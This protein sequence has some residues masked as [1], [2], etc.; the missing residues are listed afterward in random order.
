[1]GALEV[2]GKK[3]VPPERTGFVR[4][5]R[6]GAHVA[7]R[8]DGSSISVDAPKTVATVDT[9]WRMAGSTL[10][11]D[12]PSRSRSDEKMRLSNCRRQPSLECAGLASSDASSI[13]CLRP[14]KDHRRNHAGISRRASPGWWVDLRGG[15]K[16]PTR[17]RAQS[18]KLLIYARIAFIFWPRGGQRSE[19]ILDRREF[20]VTVWASRGRGFVPLGLADLA[21]PNLF[22]R[23]AASSA[24]SSSV[25]VDNDGEH[26]Q[27]STQYSTLPDYQE[28]L[29]WLHSV[30][31]PTP[32]SRWTSA[33]RPSSAPTRRSSSTATS[34][35][36]DDQGPVRHQALCAAA[37]RHLPNGRDPVQLLRHLRA[38]RREPRSLHRPPNLP[39]TLAEQ[40]PDLTYL[41]PAQI[42]PTSIGSPGTTSRPT[43]PTSQ[44]ATGETRR[45]TSGVLPFDTPTLV[46]F[47][48]T[49]IY[50]KLGLTP[51]ATWDD[52]FANS[53]AIKVRPD[54]VRLGEHG[55][56]VNV[57]I[58]YEYQAHLA[59]FG[60]SLWAMDGNTITPTINT[61]AALRP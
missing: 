34:P 29:S 5:G 51:P 61:D 56:R 19:G 28:F 11:E 7:V 43:H 31:A 53:Q 38:G 12:G 2:L 50:Q 27:S 21:S 40:Y 20:C 46:L 44:A 60:G 22:G 17:F 16:H 14:H 35:A 37:S 54:T 45:A 26:I 52:H 23:A 49:D 10:P 33:S 42:S 6:L 18:G 41:D 1:M 25:L 32:A 30:S 55:E 4:V 48:R 59:S 15:R 39:Y 47:Y 3:I 58:V 57:S 24:S 8:L 9:K 36:R 13:F